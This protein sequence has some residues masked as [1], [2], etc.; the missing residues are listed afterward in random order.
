MS[1]RSRAHLCSWIQAKHIVNNSNEKTITNV[2]NDILIELFSSNTNALQ[3]FIQNATKNQ[4][5][6]IYS[7]LKTQKMKEMEQGNYSTHISISPQSLSHFDKISQPSIVNVVAFL[8]ANDIKSFKL[9]SRR[10]AVICLQEMDKYKLGICVINKQKFMNNN[11]KTPIKWMQYMSYHRYKPSTT[12]SHILENIQQNYNIPEKYQIPVPMAMVSKYSYSTYRYNYSRV[13]DPTFYAFKHDMTLQNHLNK[14]IKTLIIFDK[15]NTIILNENNKK[16]R[17]M[18]EKDIF[19]YDKNLM[20]TL[21]HFEVKNQTINNHKN[22][23]MVHR[24]MT[25]QNLKCFIQKNILMTTANYNTI[26]LYS[27]NDKHDRK[28]IESINKLHGILSLMYHCELNHFFTQDDKNKWEIDHVQKLIPNAA[29]YLAAP[30]KYTEINLKYYYDNLANLKLQIS[31]YIEA[32]QKLNIDTDLIDNCV[33]HFENAVKLK[34]EY[35]RTNTVKILKQHISKY[36]L[37]NIIPA[38]KIEIYSSKLH[39]LN[40]PNSL[41]GRYA[42]KNIMF[43]IVKYNTN[44]CYKACKLEIFTSS[45]APFPF[46]ARRVASKASSLNVA[47]RVPYKVKTVNDLISH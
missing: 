28:P 42:Y 26:Q 9:S 34:V 32:E 45:Q 13:L 35:T 40:D 29:S 41:G 12:Y 1:K 11:H 20:I 7:L 27:M 22:H 43:E 2:I 5:D 23:L 10:L 17:K 18:N 46:K 15:R 24:S 39:N 4:L 31:E 47:I 19:N 44:G 21:H 36:Y 25:V 33:K 6:T 8:N 3:H 30:P 16:H 37:N 14:A 38:N